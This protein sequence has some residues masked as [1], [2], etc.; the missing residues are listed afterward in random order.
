MQ[1]DPKDIL[2]IASE[3]ITERGVAYGGFEQS[4]TLAAQMASL[5]LLREV[6]PYEIIVG[7]IAVKNAR[8]AYNADHFDSHLDAINYE[9]F[10]PMFADDYA[11]KVKGQPVG[12]RVA[13]A[14]PVPIAPMAP[15][16]KPAFKIPKPPREA[17]LADRLAQAA[18]GIEEQMHLLEE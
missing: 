9:A 6:H 7:L 4:F 10:L 5:R 12:E 8:S 16:N 13:P 18:S 14:P 3:T 1:H 15:Q 11:A 17:M 2:K